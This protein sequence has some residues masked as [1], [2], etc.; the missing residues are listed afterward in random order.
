MAQA[1]M[2]LEEGLETPLTLDSTLLGVSNSYKKAHK[3]IESELCDD[4]RKLMKQQKALEEKYTRSMLGLSLHD[5]I[6][7]LLVLGDLKLA[8]KMK[9]EHKMSDR[10]FYSLRI[11]H[12][13]QSFQWEELEKLSKSKKISMEAFV[14]ACIKQ[15][16][17]VEA[18]TYILKC[19]D[20]KKLKY[21]I[22]AE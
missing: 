2:A 16:K 4:D 7:E 6:K 1:E 22:R 3:D 5:T 20:D 10:H 13:S 9:N 21:L 11:D 15:H 8:E 17:M 14:E 12:L 18:L 19:R